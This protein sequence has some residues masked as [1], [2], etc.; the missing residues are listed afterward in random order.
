MC[1]HTQAQTFVPILYCMFA[2]SKLKLICFPPFALDFLAQSYGWGPYSSFFIIIIP[3]DGRQQ[4]LLEALKF[5]SLI[6]NSPTMHISRFFFVSI[7]SVFIS[8]KNTISPQCVDVFKPGH[9][10]RIKK[11]HFSGCK[12]SV[13]LSGEHNRVYFSIQNKD[14]TRS[15]CLSSLSLR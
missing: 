8:A 4:Y 11:Q 1:W 6:N 2:Q 14:D 10:R 12:C 15:G 13:L 9:V 3:L 5:H 7:S